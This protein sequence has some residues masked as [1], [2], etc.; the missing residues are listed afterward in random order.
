MFAKTLA[1][2]ILALSVLGPGLIPSYEP[3]K[4]VLPEEA[5]VLV[6]VEG[7]ED[8]TCRVVGYEKCTGEDGSGSWKAV[9][10]TEGNIGAG[11]MNLNRVRGDKS[12]PVGVWMMNTP[13][14][15]K[16]ALAGFPADYIQVTKNH[17]W[18]DDTN[19]LIVDETGKIKGERVGTESCNGFYDYVIDA[20]FNR[21]AV[22]EKGS[23]LFIH[24]Q[25]G[26]P[27]PSSGCIKIPEE[28]MIE[29]MKL[30][31]KYGTGRCF[32]VQ[33]KAGEMDKLYNA[34]GTNNGLEAKY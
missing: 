26:A 7:R 9:F 5:G 13:F 25:K 22:T 23:A 1:M 8:N 2:T 10:A 18:T 12:T 6:V 27:A 3:D 28:T 20:G 33:G 32:I 16:P 17:V 30:Y 14:G 15:Q 11:G 19:K 24:C 34:Y 21:N 31:G 29:L 4:Y